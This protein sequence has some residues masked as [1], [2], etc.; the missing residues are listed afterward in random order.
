MLK[1]VVSCRRT[2]GG[3]VFFKNT[4]IEILHELYKLQ[5]HVK[6]G[7]NFY[8]NIFLKVNKMPIKDHANHLKNILISFQFF[9]GMIIFPS[10]IVG[11]YYLLLTLCL[12]SFSAH[13]L[14]GEFTAYGPVSF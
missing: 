5:P 7:G 2:A 6:L 3:S 8:T 11:R 10:K 4:R 14:A 13:T 12:L 9:L 1:Q